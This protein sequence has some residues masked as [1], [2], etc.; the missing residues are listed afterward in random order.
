[1]PGGGAV[2]K[3]KQVAKKVKSVK[4][5]FS[6]T[7]AEPGGSSSSQTQSQP[8]VG[9]SRRRSRRPPRALSPSPPP[10]DEE[11]GDA[12]DD[13]DWQHEEG[14]DQQHEDGGDQQHEE[15]AE[16]PHQ[17]PELTG[18]EAE[19]AEEEADWASLY[20]DPADYDEQRWIPVPMDQFEERNEGMKK[21]L[22]HKVWQRGPAG[23]PERPQ[24]PFAVL[25]PKSDRYVF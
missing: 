6:K 22:P 20:E 7:V 8:A 9:A 12:E 4:S 23:L 24:N 16:E 21:P 5:L 2:K 25:I 1:M 11:E 15:G 18:E 19:E 14:G 17:Q 3:A 13:G 10:A